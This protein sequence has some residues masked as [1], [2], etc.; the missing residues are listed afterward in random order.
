MKRQQLFSSFT[1][2][3]T[4]AMLATQPVQAASMS[5]TGVKLNPTS[6]GIEVV[7]ETPRQTK[8]EVS[9][10]RSGEKF[11]ANIA[12]TQMR[13]PRGKTFRAAN[14]APE[15]A[16]VTV[17]PVTA[18]SVQ[19]TVTGKADAPIGELVQSDR[20]LVLSLQPTTSVQSPRRQHRQRQQLL[21]ESLKV[22][23]QPPEPVPPA[24]PAPSAPTTPTPIPPVKPLPGA[25]ASPPAEPA[26]DYLNPDAN[27]LQFPTKPEEVR[28]LGAQPITLQQATDLALRNNQQLEAQRLNV[29]ATQ[30]ALRQALAAE[31]PQLNL[32][33]GATNQERFLL[34]DEP[35]QGGGGGTTTAT[36]RLGLDYSLYT[37]GQ[38]RATIRAAEEQVRSSQLSVEIASEDLR[39]NVAN[40]YYNLQQAD[41]QVRI[42][43]SAVANAEASLRD[44]QALEAAGVGTRFDVLQAQVQLAQATQNLTNALS[45]QRI[46]RR[47]L[48]VQIN[49]PQSILVTAAEP[50]EISGL[51][52]F[53]LEDSIILAYQNRAELQQQLAQRNQFEQQRRAALAAL[54]PQIVLSADYNLQDGINDDQEFNDAYSV[55]AT[56]NLSLYDGGS[57]RAQA[58]QQEANVAIAEA[59]FA[60]Q[61]DLIRQD[62]EQAFSQLQSSFDNI[63]TASVALE[64]AREAL[65]LARLRFQAGVGI[66]TEVINAEDDLTISEG[67]RVTAILD[68]NRAL[69]QLQRSISSGRPR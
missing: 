4:T 16:Q 33:T 49:L 68:Y 37:S 58:R 28:I 22:A 60:Q 51:W 27:P 66:Q 8:A 62:V 6:S 9:T 25:S 34:S 41:E 1:L 47:A 55:A 31:Y 11:I 3:G 23:Q 19:V 63:Q 54:G 35:V 56:L 29:R 5:V 20:G 42:N 2:A 15:I 32:Q 44:A 50:V 26:P 38:R 40:A 12:N 7:L 18:N 53:S 69:A 46:A 48:A 30:A 17:V 43:Q 10:S 13:L 64:Q 65:R 61:R 57:A 52:N 21:V 24:T 59:Q 67:N 45:Q 14:P 39:L 36:G